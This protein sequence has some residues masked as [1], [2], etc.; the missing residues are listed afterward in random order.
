[1]AATDVADRDQPMNPPIFA[2]VGLANDPEWVALILGTW[3]SAGILVAAA[4]ARR[5]HD[6]RP[7]VALGLVLGPLLY[8][9]VRANLRGYERITPPVVVS[10]ATDR[11]GHLRVLVAV[12]GEPTDVVDALPVLRLVTPQA[13]TVEIV[14]PV[15]YDVAQS[16][17]AG[18]HDIAVRELETSAVFLHDLDP[19]LVLV[20][21]RGI[22]GVYRYAA[23]QSADVV[24]VVG[25]DVSHSAWDRASVGRSVSVV[26]GGWSHQPGHPE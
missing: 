20:P 11:G 8:G 18:G 12:I 7:L 21:G 4:Q 23:E 24:I 17:A 1:M 25:E 3:A 2:D 5:G 14:R 19:G 26:M 22:D 6:R 13:A 9:Y 15:T 10:D 16:C